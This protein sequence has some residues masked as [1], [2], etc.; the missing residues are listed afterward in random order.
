MPRS[1][2]VLLGSAA[3]AAALC[4]GA[5]AQ[6]Q[7]APDP[8]DSFHAPPGVAD[9]IWGE[10]PVDIRDGVARAQTIDQVS[11]ATAPLDTDPVLARRL[12]D[13]CDTSA[14]GPDPAEIVQHTI[15]P[16]TMEI[17]A[18]GQLKTNDK[19]S[20]AALARAWA[21]VPADGRARL[22]DWFIHSLDP[23]I[24]PTAVLRPMLAALGLDAEA[25]RR[26][27]LTY[28]AARALYEQ[29]GGTR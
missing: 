17:W 27:V 2:D 21:R 1:R 4:L 13:A 25:P 19:V 16:K 15:V 20:D 9:C 5:E 28:A 18:A 8:Q 10:L 26:L 11:A 22:A 3:L 6:A 7:P 12:G 24:A 29:M 23:K 14:S